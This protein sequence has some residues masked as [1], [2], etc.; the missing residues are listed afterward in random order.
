VVSPAHFPKISTSDNANNHPHQSIFY[1]KQYIPSL[2]EEIE[3]GAAA[4]EEPQFAMPELSSIKLK[5]K[6][7]NSRMTNNKK[8]LQNIISG[9]TKDINDVSNLLLSFKKYRADTMKSL[10]EAA[11]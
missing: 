7:Y 1:D 9:A 6:M 8:D 5:K 11:A 2:G 10:K 4:V 3:A